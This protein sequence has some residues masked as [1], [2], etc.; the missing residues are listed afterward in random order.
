MALM[1]ILSV[2]DAIARIRHMI[3]KF[4]DDGSKITAGLMMIIVF[5]GATLLFCVLSVISAKRIEVGDRVYRYASYV[6]L[7]L[8]ILGGI[9][10]AGLLFSPYVTIVP[11]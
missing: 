3:W 4:D 1:Q 5:F 2:W 11:R 6:S 9:V 7:A 8:L 10:W